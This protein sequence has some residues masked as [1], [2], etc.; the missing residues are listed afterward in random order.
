MTVGV[1]I[2]NTRLVSYSRWNVQAIDI[3][4]TVGDRDRSRAEKNARIFAG[5][6]CY[7]YAKAFISVEVSK[8][9]RNILVGVGHQRQGCKG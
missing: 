4:G 8:S 5:M 9:Y 3:S 7:Y 1:E 2:R 6:I